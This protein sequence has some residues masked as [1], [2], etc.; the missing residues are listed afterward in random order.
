MLLWIDLAAVLALAVCSLWFDTFV[1]IS[2]TTVT[3]ASR[4]LV[5]VVLWCIGSRLITRSLKF[6]LHSAFWAGLLLFNGGQILLLAFGT[7]RR[8][9]LFSQ[10][11]EYHLVKMI[12]LVA[13][14]LLAANC[15]GNVARRC[16]L[17]RQSRRS[18]SWSTD[19]RGLRIVSYLVL[20]ATVGPWIAT[21]WDRLQ[22]V[23]ALGYFYGS[24]TAEVANGIAHAP[25][26]LA[27]GFDAGIIMLLAGATSAWEIWLSVG[28]EAACVA[29]TVF[30]GTKA[31]LFQLIGYLWVWHVRIRPIPR[32]IVAIGA[33]LC[34]VLVPL[35]TAV[36]E[37]TGQDRLS[38]EYV[39]DTYSQMENPI[40]AGL[41]EMGWTASI[42]TQATVTTPANQPFEYGTSYLYGFLNIVPNVFGGAHP[43]KVHGYLAD[44]HAGLVTPRLA[45]LGGGWGYSPVAEAYINFGVLGVPLILFVMG[46]IS[47][48]AGLVAKS[49]QLIALVGCSFYHL[50]LF[51]RGESATLLR[52]E[53]WYA[54]LPITIAV[55]L[56]RRWLVRRRLVKGLLACAPPSVGNTRRVQTSYR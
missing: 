46:F 15:G 33:V 12:L 51:T 40:E 44:R 56:D 17:E 49:P 4:A 37:T 5:G 6:E 34:L 52:G 16:R 11:S 21:T 41:T 7:D 54:L 39:A 2:D 1:P 30:M 28:L 10:F 8:P 31:E 50:I 18:R 22:A 36:R 27:L 13:L 26:L 3:V 23:M 32:A 55:G 29:T 20:F 42:V 47:K 9:P 53:A 35:I 24:F 45:A 14:G 19:H 38:L 48:Y 25:V 43:S